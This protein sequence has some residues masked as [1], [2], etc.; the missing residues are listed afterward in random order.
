MAYLKE[1][2]LNNTQRSNLCAIP[3][4]VKFKD[5]NQGAINISKLPPNSTLSIHTT[6]SPPQ[7]RDAVPLRHEL[8]NHP[9]A[10]KKW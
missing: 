2:C 4:K 3:L 7:S 10:A 8:K 9:S 1:G 6:N 5:K